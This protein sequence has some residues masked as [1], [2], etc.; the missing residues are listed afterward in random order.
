MICFLAFFLLFSCSE[1]AEVYY[2]E[3]PSVLFSAC[4]DIQMGRRVASYIEE[5]GVNYPFELCADVTSGADLSFCNLE[6][7]L[8][9]R[10]NIDKLYVFHAET[11][12]VEGLKFAGFNL[13]CVANNHIDD[14]GTLGFDEN[15]GILL[16]NDFAVVGAG[17]SAEKST[18]PIIVE[19]NG[20]LF[21]LFGAQNFTA[22]GGYAAENWHAAGIDMDDLCRRI[23]LL[24]GRVDFTI[25]SM[26]WGE[27]YEFE[28]TEVQKEK[29]TR[30]AEAGCDLLIGHHPHVLETIENIDGSLIL[31]S[32][33]NFV[34]DCRSEI[35]C[36][37]AVFQA[38]FSRGQISFPQLIPF[39]IT[40][41]R[42]V[43]DQEIGDEIVDLYQKDENGVRLL[44]TSS[45]VWIYSTSSAEIFE[46]P[47]L[48]ISDEN[49]FVMPSSL[50]WN[51]QSYR[52]PENSGNVWRAALVEN[53]VCL[54]FSPTNSSQLP[55]VQ[56]FDLSKEDFSKIPFSEGYFPKKMEKA[57]DDLIVMIT[58]R[59]AKSK[60]AVVS[61][62]PLWLFEIPTTF[63]DFTACGD[64][65]L[66][67]FE[68]RIVQTSVLGTFLD[69]EILLET[70]EVSNQLFYLDG[71]ILS[72]SSL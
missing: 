43:L 16:S 3:E 55:S 40:D 46:R 4:G 47:V 71:E 14:T 28:P 42:P 26:H 31:Y 27:E 20:L 24:E 38:E 45:N 65:I 56:I 25:V 57:G 35:Q 39:R 53:C 70:Q 18:Y 50:T 69:E 51:D 13:V 64:E 5:N 6:S 62:S 48:S 41:F 34:F 8:S 72:V 1:P 11:N 29:A 33:G 36:R 54:F 2:Y 59:N 37:T 49:L 22:P 19:K 23:Q 32:L 12:C 7:V 67:L 61:V 21:A 52:Y 9:S 30:L 60:I 68:D 66:L 44:S 15:I 58:N 63:Q 17:R 10:T